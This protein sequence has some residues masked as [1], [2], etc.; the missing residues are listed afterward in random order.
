[1]S[2]IS[3]PGS[4]ESRRKRR[5]KRFISHRFFKTGVMEL[6]NEKARPTSEDLPV[7]KLYPKSMLV[8]MNVQE[9]DSTKKGK[10]T[11]D[12]WKRSDKLSTL[13]L[14]SIPEDI[15]DEYGS[16]DKQIKFDYTYVVDP[17]VLIKHTDAPILVGKE[18]HNSEREVQLLKDKFKDYHLIYI[19]EEGSFIFTKNPKDLSKLTGDY[20]DPEVIKSHDFTESDLKV[21]LKIWD[22]DIY[23]VFGKTNEGNLQ[24]LDFMRGKCSLF[25]RAFVLSSPYICNVLTISLPNSSCRVKDPVPDQ[26]PKRVI[27][28][29]EVEIRRKLGGAEDQLI[30]LRSSALSG[31]TTYPLG[32]QLQVSK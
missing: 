16:E 15:N 18:P 22:E 2:T 28:R 4:K 30:L 7:H 31:G 5:L 23:T 21:R 11:K 17:D 29:P 20:S 1:M 27:R 14:P 9:V 3:I 25:F 24:P 32:R 13:Y 8:S 26:E 10:N 19:D 6:G 12:I